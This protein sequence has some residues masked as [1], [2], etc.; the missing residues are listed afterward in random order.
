MEIAAMVLA[1]IGT[2]LGLFSFGK[3]I[4]GAAKRQR[5]AEKAEKE[6]R[7]MMTEAKALATKNYYDQLQVPLGAYEKQFRENTAQ[8]MQGIQALQE[9]GG[10]SLIGGIGKIHGQATDANQDTTNSL[11]E[12]LYANDLQKAKAAT[13]MN[14]RLIDIEV[15]GAADASLRARDQRRLGNQEMAIGI[16]G[17]KGAVAAGSEFV[18]LYGRKSKAQ[19][20]FSNLNTKN[21]AQFLRKDGTKMSRKEILTQ[22]GNMSNDQQDLLKKDPDSFDY[23]GVQTYGNSFSIPQDYALDPSITNLDLSTLTELYPYLNNQANQ[24]LYSSVGGNASGLGLT[25]YSVF[26]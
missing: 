7:N 3:N 14:D 17:L 16:E 2:T 25:D 5:A 6:S 10:R 15:G 24:G 13:V 8:Q 4:S 18:P 23:T 1:G 26:K 9:A 19:D 11:A 12:A 20:V 21:K 22:I